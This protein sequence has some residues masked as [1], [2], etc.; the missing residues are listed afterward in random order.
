MTS[1]IKNRIFVKIIKLAHPG[2]VKNGLV[3]KIFFYPEAFGV[4]KGLE[5][6]ANTFSFEVVWGGSGKTKIKK[7][8]RKY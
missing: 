1:R 4:G 8:T 3:G 6:L 2:I 5:K 7:E